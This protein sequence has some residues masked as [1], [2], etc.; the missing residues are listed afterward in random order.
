MLSRSFPIL[1][2]AL[3]V[4]LAHA[5]A[6]PSQAAPATSANFGFNPTS[7]LWQGLL[8]DGNGNLKTTPG[9]GSAGGS[10]GNPLFTA[11]RLPTGTGAAAANTVVAVSSGTP[12]VLFSAASIANG[13]FVQNPAGNTVALV[14]DWG[15]GTPAFPVAPE[16]LPPGA[17]VTCQA[18]YTNAV[19]MWLASGTTSVTVNA[20]RY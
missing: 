4:P 16:S 15:G 1:A 2:L 18:A 13:C 3:A 7:R 5:S 12:V 19:N 14:V 8:V 20:G 10:A 6:Q 17:V 11:S 9:T